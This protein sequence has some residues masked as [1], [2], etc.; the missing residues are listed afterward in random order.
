MKEGL[1]FE[2]LSQGK[3]RCCLCPHGCIFGPGGRGRCGVRWNMGGTLIASNYGKAGGYGLDPVEKKPLY[4]FYP[5][6]YVLSVG[7]RGC[8]FRCDFCQNWEL[9]LGGQHNE[10]DITPMGLI[11][12]AERYKSYYDVIG[13]AFTYSEPFMWYEFLLDACRTAKDNGMK[14]VIVTN[15]FIEKA[16]LR[17]ILPLVDAMNID[18]KAFTEEFY[19]KVVHG[20]L[21]PVL[22][23]A[24]TVKKQGCHVEITTLLIPGLNDSQQEITK[25][26]E[27]IS[28]DLGRDTPL[29]F[30]RYFPN[31]K[32]DLEATPVK[33]LERAGELAKERLDYVYLGNLGPGEY[34]NTF[35]PVCGQMAV[36]RN[37]GTVDTS[38]LAEGRCANCGKALNIIGR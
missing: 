5:G 12:A 1:W 18:I 11:N 6:A 19:A 33:V 27:W 10:I 2:R 30:S 15:G 31:Y 36:L 17:Q 37:A 3:V 29:H 35:C 22:K 26:A 28:S 38:G 20:S 13:L 8:N 34:M 14:N 21:K 9:A 32:M 4:H 7:A 23:T 25:L 24:E 16:P